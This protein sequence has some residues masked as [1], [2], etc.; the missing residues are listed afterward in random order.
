[1]TNANRTKVARI[2]KDLEMLELCSNGVGAGITRLTYSPEEQ[3]A[4]AYLSEQMRQ[5]GMSVRLD[6]AGNVIGRIEGLRPDLPIIMIGS[7][8]DSIRNGGNFDGMAGVVAGIEVARTIRDMGISPLRS[9][10]VVGIT[11]E[12]NSR[13]FPGVVGSRAMVGAISLDEINS[14]RGSDGIMMS[15][16]MRECGLDPEQI[17]SAIRPTG[18]IYMYFELHIEQCKVLECNQIPVGI[19]TCICGAAHQAITIYG[20]ADHAGGTPMSMRSD[21]VM[22]IAEV[23]LEAERLANEVGHDT[24]ATFGKL[25]VVPNIP[26]VI[27][28]EVHVMADIRSSDLEC[29]KAV[30]NGIEKKLEEVC[31][32]RGC[33]FVSKKELHDPPTLVPQKMIEMLT[34]KANELGIPN[35][36]I[37][38]GAGHDSVVI[39]KIAPVAML[40]VPSK[41]GRSHC[42]EEWTNYEDIQKGTEVLL[43]GV[44]ELAMSETDEYAK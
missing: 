9:I 30:M 5:A 19:V 10:E 3:Q 1:M 16:A 28:G 13:F 35:Q 41:G 23:A 32:R 25:D 33:T 42:P 8:I 36:L 15:D 14:T 21:A 43:S 26:N 7:H 37:Y 34:R 24:V 17:S 12:E 27:P 29:N 6:A 22:A 11:G 18:S 20:Q 44:L 31:A 40:F 4:R 2:Q 38:S 39:N